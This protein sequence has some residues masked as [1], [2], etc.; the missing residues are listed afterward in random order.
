M[1]NKILYLILII[2]SVIMFYKM[3]KINFKKFIILISI[4]IIIIYI[5]NIINNN[6]DIELF[7]NNNINYM[8]DMVK[9]RYND[10]INKKSEKC[11]KD[12]EKIKENRVDI[13]DGIDCYNY[14]SNEIVTNNNIDSWC[15]LNDTDNDII[16]NAI[17]NLN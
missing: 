6:N 15:N 4:I 12:F 17:K 3:C 2:I 14:V 8:C 9:N 5:I 13:N 1:C 10:L 16:N 11:I 7:S